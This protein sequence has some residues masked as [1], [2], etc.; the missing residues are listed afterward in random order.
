V[1]RELIAGPALG[2]TASR[3]SGHRLALFRPR[4]SAV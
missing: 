2:G 3:T 4:R 1:A